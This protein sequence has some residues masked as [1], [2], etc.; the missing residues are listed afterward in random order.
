MRETLIHRP[1]V[2]A[3]IGLL[4][5]VC[6]LQNM[7]AIALVVGALAFFRNVKACL[8][9]AAAF[10][11]GA[12]FAPSTAKV[13]FPTQW[14][15]A[16]ATVIGVPSRYSNETIAEIRIANTNLLLSGPPDLPLALGETIKIQ[17]DVQPLAEASQRLSDRGIEGRIWVERIQVIDPPPWPDRIGQSW[18]DSFIDFTNRSV[19]P[20]SAAVIQAVTFNSR[21][22]LSQNQKEE[23]SRAGTVH[24]L[25]TSGLHGGLFMI[26]LFGLLSLLPIPR[27]VQ[28]A[29]VGVV[30]VLYAIASGLHPA[31]I[32][33]AVVA[34]LL[35]SAYLVRR[36]PDLL[37]A[38]AVAVIVQMLWDAS[39]IYDPGFQLTF[40]VLT[41]IALFM[42][43]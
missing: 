5:G 41:A 42:P 6:T 7:F 29:L 18:R 14:L 19:D 38:I 26:V 40:T 24:A 9:C 8:I 15:K 3:A 32:R 20:S 16:Q 22:A 12:F 33:A 31:V 11:L 35:C 37:S 39:A 36:E 10:L 28:I 1:M 2:L 43:F 34:I 4:L 30:L 23:F 25:S 17:G 13:F 27:G 21:S